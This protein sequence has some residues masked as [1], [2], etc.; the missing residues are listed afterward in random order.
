MADHFYNVDDE[1]ILDETLD[2]A[3]E[4]LRH[5][6]ISRGL[7][8]EPHYSAWHLCW[9][10]TLGNDRS[11]QLSAVDKPGIPLGI[12]PLS[13]FDTE[14]RDGVDHER[15]HAH[16]ARHYH[17]RPPFTRELFEETL[18]FAFRDASSTDPRNHPAYKSFAK[19]TPGIKAYIK[20]RP[21]H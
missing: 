14:E 18:D 15:R 8:L 13:W 21:V 3:R 7:D 1:P 19:R 2:S 4:W 5:Y 20:P 11:I 17:L 12:C 16:I 10:D 6:A 9:I